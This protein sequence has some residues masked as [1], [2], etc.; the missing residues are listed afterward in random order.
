MVYPKVKVRQQEDQDDRHAVIDFCFPGEMKDS[1]MEELSK[2]NI[3]ASSIPRPRAVLSSPE[4]DMVIGNKNRIKAERPSALKNHN[5]VKKPT[6]CVPCHITE[7]STKT[8]KSKDE[9]SLKERKGSGITLPSQR[10]PPR[11][12]KPS[13]TGNR[14]SF[15][16]R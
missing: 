9:N 10:R 2:Q 12:G 15:S 6:L 1:K 5:L 13:S 14:V 16:C 4:N 3:R 11:N 8:K 7:N